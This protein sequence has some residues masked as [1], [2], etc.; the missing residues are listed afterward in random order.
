MRKIIGLIFILSLT[1]NLNAQTKLTT[2][3]SITVFYD[4]LLNTLKSDYLYK[5]DVNWTSLENE[6]KS[7]LKQFP[8]F[9]SSLAQTTVLFDK[10]KATHCEVFYNDSTSYTATFNGPTEKDFSEQ[11]VKKYVTTPSFEVKVIDNKYGYILMPGINFTDISAENI[12]KLAQPMYDQIA[13]IKNNK[14]LAGWIIDL[15][16]NT[17]GNCHPMLLTL[18]DFLGDNMVYG[19]LDINK[20]LFLSVKMKNGKYFDNG[21]LTSQIIPKGKKMTKTKVAIITGKATGSSGEI[22]A[23]SF[24]GRKNTIFIGEPTGGKTTTNDKRDLPFGIVMAL[25]IG[26]DCDRN[27]IGYERIIPDILI[28]KQDNFENL[29]EDKNIEEAMRWINKK[30]PCSRF[31]LGW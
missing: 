20:K 23:M 2:K 12:Q 11:W 5:N 10:I 4:S 26:Y 7:N 28:S 15:R 6:T 22:T 21:E 30:L 18:Y 27:K 3:D 24:K 9:R 13:E 8:D 17:G 16:F 29:L 14:K 1:L 31:S 25:T 19:S